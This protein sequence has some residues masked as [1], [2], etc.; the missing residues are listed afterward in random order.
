MTQQRRTV[1]V[2]GGSG[3]LG[4]HVMRRFG[5]D[6]WLIVAP[7]SSEVDITD[8]EATIAAIMACGPDVIVHTAYRKNDGRVTVDGT[9]HVAE[10]AAE[11][12]SRLV[13]IS[14]DALF[15]GRPDPYRESDPPDPITEYGRHKADAEAAV[16]AS[17]PDAV[18]LRTSLLYGT[19][20]PSPAQVELGAS[21]RSGQSP[22]TFFSDEYRCPVHASDVADAIVVLATRPEAPGVIH[23]AGPEPVSRADFARAL[24]RYDGLADVPIAVTTTTEAGSNRPAHVVLDTSLAASIGIT[25]RPLADSLVR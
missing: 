22:M 5:R 12:G 7:T 1:F 24:A 19:D 21:L 23:V 3:Y 17:A 2:T 10:A 9:R 16:I 8:R 25:C 13:H 18:I 20:H 4:A 15:A 6:G 11:R 14:T